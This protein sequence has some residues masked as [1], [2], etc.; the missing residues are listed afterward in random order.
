MNLKKQVANF[1]ILDALRSFAVLN[2]C[3]AHA[4]GLLWM[5]MGQYLKLNPYNTWKFYDYAVAALMSLTKLSA[6][7]VIFFFVLSGFSIVHSLVKQS[8]MVSLKIPEPQRSTFGTNNIA[9]A[10]YF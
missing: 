6:E 9:K 8:V 3:I 10:K 2:V 7:F 1:S 4:R 5:G